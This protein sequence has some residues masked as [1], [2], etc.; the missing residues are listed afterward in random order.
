MDGFEDGVD[1]L[2]H[3]AFEEPI[4][5]GDFD[6]AREDE[7]H[8]A[9]VF[10]ITAT[11]R[12]EPGGNAGLLVGGTLGKS[13]MAASVAFEAGHVVMQRD[14]VA[15]FE[16]S[17]T[18]AD[19]DDGAGGFVAENA[20]RRNGS[21]LDFF[22][23][24]RTDAAG[25]DFDQEIAGLDLGYRQRFDSQIVWAPIDDCLHGRRNYHVTSRATVY[26]GDT[27]KATVSESGAGVGL[28]LGLRLF[29][30]R[31]RVAL[32]LREPG[33]TNNGSRIGGHNVIDPSRK[34]GHFDPVGKEVQLQSAQA[35]SRTAGEA[36]TT[37]VRHSDLTHGIRKIGKIILKPLETRGPV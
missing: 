22:D 6:D 14:A 24:G 31:G 8:D 3:G 11:G 29:R 10:G 4:A 2:E 16:F 23:V 7:G 19:L 1:R 35:E 33:A 20:G 36:E 30:R 15:D 5:F 21:I 17:D 18:F 34:F 25:G 12:F 37:S 28:L 27:A 9:D 13:S 32:E 26:A